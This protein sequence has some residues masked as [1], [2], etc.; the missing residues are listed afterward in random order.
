MDIHRIIE[1]INTLQLDE[2][3]QVQA[4][5]KDLIAR[6]EA[7]SKQP[8]STEAPASYQAYQDMKAQAPEDLGE[9]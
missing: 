9:K 2:L 4:H 6:L 8:A 5:V 3:R 7:S 1:S